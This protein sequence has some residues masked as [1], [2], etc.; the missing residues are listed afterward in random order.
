MGERSG[1]RVYWCA[2]PHVP[3]CAARQLIKHGT[4]PD[5][6]MT[7]G[8][9]FSHSEIR[10]HIEEVWHHAWGWVLFLDGR[11]TNVVFCISPAARKLIGW[12]REHGGKTPPMPKGMLGAAAKTLCSLLIK[13]GHRP[14][15]PLWGGRGCPP[16]GVDRARRLWACDPRRGNG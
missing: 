4:K 7:P 3:P 10:K 1:Q 13:G 5:T 6:S 2:G 16:V 12:R 8:G 14:K 15:H 9:I 11:R